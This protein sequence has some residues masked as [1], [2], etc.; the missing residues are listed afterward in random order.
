M[1]VDEGDVGA[2]YWQIGGRKDG[3]NNR[4]I[5]ARGPGE[6]TA[7]HGW[8]PPGEVERQQGGQLQE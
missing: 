1:F 2:H 5:C 7:L 3:L 4:G 6:V 8:E